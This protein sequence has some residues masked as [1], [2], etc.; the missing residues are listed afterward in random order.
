MDFDCFRPRDFE[1]DF[2]D[3]EE[4]LIRRF[5]LALLLRLFSDLLLLGSRLRL[6]L[7]DAEWPRLRLFLLIFLPS[8]FG[9]VS[10]LLSLDRDL[11]KYLPYEPL[12]LCSIDKIALL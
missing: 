10:C 6:V 5:L 4:R 2:R 8:S 12:D 11:T 1:R 3:S 7:A 9:L